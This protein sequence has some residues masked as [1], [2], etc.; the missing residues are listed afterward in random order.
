MKAFAALVEENITTSQS[1]FMCGF[2]S[3]KD[4]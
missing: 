4:T 3:D 1:D 2:Q